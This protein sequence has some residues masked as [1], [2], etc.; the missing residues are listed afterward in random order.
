MGLDVGSSVIKAAIGE[1][2]HLNQIKVLGLAQVPSTGV[3]KGN[4]VD[5]D[6]TARA[7]EACLN[8][9]ERL[10]GVEIMSTITGFSSISLSAVNIRAVIAVGSTNGE[11][12]REDRERVLHSAKNLDLPP[13]RTVVQVLERQYIIDGYEGVKDPVGMMG[14]RLEAEVLILVAATAAVQNLQRCVQRINL[15]LGQLA[16]NQLLAAEAVLLPA[17]K[18]VGVALVDIGGGTTEISLFNRGFLLATTVL[19]IGSDHISKDLAIVLRTSLDEATQVKENYGIA[20]PEMIS[21]DII[22]N[23]HNL[24]GNQ[25]RPVAQ[26]LIAEIISARVLE[27]LEMIYNELEKTTDLDNLPGGLVLT[28]GG[29][30]LNGLVQLM[31]AYLDIPVRLGIPA[32]LKGLQDEINKPQNAVVLGS[33]I[34]GFNNLEPFIVASRTGVS[35]VFTK[36]NYW[37]KDLFA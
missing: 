12:S 4:L 32:N 16:Y 33:L 9:L 26:E 14:N 21:G 25:T 15:H 5:V 20:D 28:G 17:E 30:Q 34:Y 36:I 3:R 11:I 1:V 29:A 31:E 35:S 8:E 6:G 7:V 27:M 23:V 19:P 10:T 37:L 24:Q 18:E 13:D 22:I 2:T